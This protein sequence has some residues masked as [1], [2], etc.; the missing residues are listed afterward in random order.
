MVPILGIPES[1]LGNIAATGQRR[2]ADTDDREQACGS[3]L[4]GLLHVLSEM[5]CPSGFGVRADGGHIGHRRIAESSVVKITLTG[6]GTAL[7]ININ[8]EGQT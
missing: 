8:E 1:V 7:K 6:F 3:I 5:T 2:T 4:C